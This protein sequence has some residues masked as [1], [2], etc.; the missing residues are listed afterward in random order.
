M[1]KPK[2]DYD[3]MIGLPDDPGKTW[4]TTV[5][6]ND[7]TP[8]PSYDGTTRSERAAVPRRISAAGAR[9]RMKKAQR[10]P[11]PGPDEYVQRSIYARHETFEKLKRLAF[12]EEIPAQE[13]Y[14]EGL[15]LV[16]RKYR[17]AEGMTIDEV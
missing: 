16:L 7:S 11:K 4:G 6:S 2:P 10:K 8:V 5:Q 17:V 3:D 15:L 14:R 1:P 13:L 12:A 9:A